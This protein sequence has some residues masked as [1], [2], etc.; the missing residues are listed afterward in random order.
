MA[1]ELGRRS[2]GG[3][4]LPRDE[5]RRR[6]R[7]AV[8]I[9]ITAV[10]AIA[11]A[12]LEVRLPRLS[13]S[14]SPSG[15]VTFFLL[16]NL[17]LILLIL[18]IFLVARNLTK[19]VFERRH[20]ILGSRLRTRLVGAFVSLSIVPALL[21]FLVAE[22]FLTAVIE[23][24]FSSRVEGAMEAARKLAESY[25]LQRGSDALRAARELARQIQEYGLLNATLQK[26]LRDLIA[27][28]RSELN[29]DGVEVIV[30]QESVASS[31]SAQRP[32]RIPPAVDLRAT[33]LEGAE[34]ARTEV[35]DGQDIVRAGTPIRE[36]RGAILG[37][38]VT[39]AFV[40][41]DLGSAALQAVRSHEEYRHLKVLKQPIRNGYTLSF[42]LVTLVVVFSATWF[43]FRL[44]KGITVPI[45]RLGEGMQEVAQGKWDHRVEMEGDEEMASLIESFNR[46]TIDLETIHSALEDRRRYI[47]NILEN[48]TAGVVS[49]DA[50]GI[51]ATV[52]PAAAA[53]LRLA[54]QEPRSRK[55]EE[56][57]DRP[58]LHPIG[59]LIARAEAGG[60][61]KVE[62]QIEL[63]SGTHTLTTWVTA[64]TLA[65]NGGARRSIIL[66]LEDVTHL[67]RVE[68]MEAWREVARRIAHE[69]KNPL[70]PIQLS[71]QRLRK[72]YLEASREPRHELLDECTRTII[73]Q[74]EQLKRLVDEFSTFARLPA[75]Q[76]APHNLNEIAEDAVILFREAHREIR[77]EFRPGAGL[78]QIEIDR[79]AIKRALINIL[80]NAVAACGKQ[81]APAPEI[82]V[83]TTC[84][85]TAGAVRLEVADNGCGLTPE[86]KARAFEPYFST[87]RD[88][89]GLG[90]AIVST[91]VADHRAYVRLRDNTP[92]GTRVVIEFPLRKP[93]VGAMA[94]QA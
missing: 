78:P 67:L 7:E 29:L 46:M 92:R 17:N 49:I 51:V 6:Q 70:T 18:L 44:A 64:T 19:L 61:D 58:D 88:G 55:W 87:K 23:N 85:P 80:D 91:I 14:V 26:D 43:G 22:G 72:R 39:S 53:M 16:I 76:V 75:I 82:E 52:N 81:Q 15:S 38:V 83:S 36:P 71:A 93:R 35:V 84:D 48:I 74:V 42:L 45:Q 89:T 21:L 24:W 27:A 73:G 86:V 33:L 41:R 69:I 11:F 20:G 63:N 10:A 68:R 37:A 28:R 50:N 5:V 12:V 13:Q 8:L 30:G 65:E 90:L 79:D 94:M 56:V 1:Q 62:G 54:P 25:Y 40:P 4:A 3:P 32:T 59:D 9:A 34:F 2:G 31:W 47:E 57:F 66:F 77:F 60:G